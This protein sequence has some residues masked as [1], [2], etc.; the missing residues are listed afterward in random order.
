MSVRVPEEVVQWV[1]RFC[2][3][4]SHW[5][6]RGSPMTAS[7]KDTLSPRQSAPRVWFT[8]HSQT[9]LHA[10]VVRPVRFYSQGG[11]PSEDSE[12]R[13]SAVAAA[14]QAKRGSP[15]LGRLRQCDSLSG[16]LD[17][18]SQYAPTGGQISKCLVRMWAIIKKMPDEQQRSELQLLFAHPAFDKLLQNA[19]KSVAH[20]RN[21]EVVFSLLA[22]V[23][24]GVPQRSRV[25]QTFLRGCQEKL[26]DF[27]HRSLSVLTL[28]L[29]HMPSSPNVNAIR[30]G[31]R[32]IVETRHPQI[33]EVAV[34]NTMIGMLGKDAPS[35]LKR[36]LERKAL[37]ISDQF[38][39]PNSQSMIFTMAK[40]GFNS[41]PL[42]EICSKNITE[43]I[44][45]IPVNRLLM[46]LLSCKELNYRD[47]DLLTAI[48]DYVASTLD[49]LSNKQVML[50]LT[51][52]HHLF[53]CPA[54]LMEAYAEKVIASPDALTLQDLLC[55]LK[56][57]SSLN[58]D[59][60]HHRQQFLDSLSHVLDFYVPEMSRLTLLKAVFFLC[61]L[62][63]FPSA[64]LEQLLQSSTI[65]EL[66]ASTLPLNQTGMFKTVDLCLRL[67]R[68]PLPRPLSVP[69]SVLEDPT[70]SSPSVNKVLSQGLQSV[71]VNQADAMLQE[72]VMVENF[73][74]IDGVITKPLPNQTSASGAGSSDGDEL[75]PA[76]SSQR[77]AVL[78]IKYSA[79]CY[80]TSNPR[81]ALAVKIRHLKI[82][83]YN[84]ILVSE[85][86]L[87]SVSEDN[88]T[89]FLRGLIFP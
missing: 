22:M 35:H 23:K 50:F 14:G 78:N 72:M 79:L 8:G 83:G 61:Q 70:P 7:V 54:S 74:L 38:S 51:V 41:K 68:P 30:E 46:L 6:Q 5:T 86:E 29:T 59:L 9:H 67:D 26:N 84:P 2:G 58:C 73:Y 66:N 53:F 48:S 21:E 49:I 80:G 76:E 12:Q 60:Q 10:S 57:Y 11:V 87:L 88:R 33:Q 13:E 16:A 19:M 45:R 85:Q 43:N 31:M 27:D 1:L 82:L 15:F 17:L 47:M 18:T 63:Q 69:P 28:C 62:G 77:I 81:G 40:I 65:E 42:L 36:K 32:L 44:H 71:M 39:F 55:V 34:L 37:T 24:L 20:M 4:R 56:V 3:R 75:S 64:P 52:F 25:V 89:E